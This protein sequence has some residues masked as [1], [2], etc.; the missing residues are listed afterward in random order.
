M[1]HFLDTL[2]QY[3]ITH[4]HHNKKLVDLFF[5]NYK[6][7]FDFEGCGNIPIYPHYRPVYPLGAVSVVWNGQMCSPEAVSVAM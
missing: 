4:M 7:L 5:F 2:N 6:C 3:S 1:H